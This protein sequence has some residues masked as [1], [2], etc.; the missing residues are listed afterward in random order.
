VVSGDPARVDTGAGGAHDA[1]QDARQLLSQLDAALDV[2]A[3][4][5]AHGNHHVG[6]DQIDQLLG[7]LLDLQHIHMDVG[8]V[9]LHVHV[10]DL[11]LR[12]TGLVIGLGLHDAGTHGGHLGTEAGADDGGHQVTAEGRTGHLQVGVLLELG[13]VHVDGGGGLQEGLVLL[14]VHVQVG[15]VGGQAGVQAGRAAGAQVTADVGGAD[16]EDLGLLVLHQVTDDLGV[17]VGGVDIQQLVVAVVHLVGAV[18]AQ[19]LQVVLL[20]VL[21]QHHAAQLHAQVV[22]Q[23]AALGEELVA[24][25]HNH[26]LALL[27]ENPYALEG[28]GILTIKSHCVALLSLYQMMCLS[29]RMETSFSTVALSAPSIIIPAPFTGGEKDLY[30]FV[31]EPFR[32]MVSTSMRGSSFRVS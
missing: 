32:P 25:G 22:G 1:A 5:A 10:D 17:G 12:G 30:T 18:A 14:H 4:A 13:V 6:A 24:G 15:A 7:G 2:L 28:G 11:R 16:E 9:Q 23:L 3:D 27:T 21:A 19:G 20:D 8:L 31:G 26:A 29:L